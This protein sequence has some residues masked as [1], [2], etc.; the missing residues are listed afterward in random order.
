M[1]N[2]IKAGLSPESIQYSI[3]AKMA[4]KR[5]GTLIYTGII[6]FIF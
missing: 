2:F 5:N 3:V 6:F 1:G 4:K